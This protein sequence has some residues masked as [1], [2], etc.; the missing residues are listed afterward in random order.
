MFGKT[1]TRRQAELAALVAPRPPLGLTH[2]NLAEPPA[3]GNPRI[4]RHYLHSSETWPD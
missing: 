3:L 1:N 4:S 2:A